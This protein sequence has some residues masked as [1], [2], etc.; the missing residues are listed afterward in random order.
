MRTYIS[1]FGCPHC[2]SHVR[3]TDEDIIICANSR[4]GVSLAYVP[5]RGVVAG[6]DVDGAFTPSDIALLKKMR[7]TL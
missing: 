1:N 3:R 5:G 6:E 2:G 7:V 4:C